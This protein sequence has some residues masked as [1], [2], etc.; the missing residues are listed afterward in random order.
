MTPYVFPVSR[1]SIMV[2]AGAFFLEV[3]DA[4]IMTPTLVAIASAMDIGVDAATI[5]VATYVLALALFT[6]LGGSLFPKLTLKQKVLMGIA[7]F[8]VGR[9]CVQSARI[10]TN[11]GR[12]E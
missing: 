8:G 6:P 7:I 11:W 4:S 3:L 1:S 2:V 12:A 5:S 10:F 9:L